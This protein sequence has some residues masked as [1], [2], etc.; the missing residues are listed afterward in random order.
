M[1]REAIPLLITGG[2]GRIGGALRQN[3]PW[4]MR[5]GLRPIWQS[6]Q[7]R[8]GYLTW[9]VLDAACPTLA[10]GGIVL[11][12]AGGRGC[13][14][15]A[16]TAL[17][18]AA[19]EAAGRHVFVMSSAAVYGDP[20]PDPV[21]EDT[22]LRPV[23]EYGR[24]KAAMEAAVRSWH[25]AQGKAAPGLTILRLGNVAGFDALLGAAQ[26]GVPVQLDPISGQT[27]GPVRSYI[28]PG[29]LS[30]VLA[31]LVTLAAKGDA[32]PQVLNIAAPRP[33]SMAGLLE[34]AG[35]AWAFGPERPE[36]IARVALNTALLQSLVKLP[37]PASHP[38][39]MVSEWRGSLR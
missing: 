19:C 7:P 4:M 36:A 25:S 23:S 22:P 29:T 24:A 27:G 2:T 10:Q 39:A 3:W 11:C 26:T 28:G 34:A 32:L 38:A 17:A 15:E 37:P 5:G 12:L 9:D 14:E 13:S 33:V 35:M 16:Q 21:T 18:L 8:P 1:A 31:Q 30:A 20:G 6:R